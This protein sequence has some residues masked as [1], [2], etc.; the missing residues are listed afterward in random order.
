[1]LTDDR[2]TKEGMSSVASDW[3]R[4]GDA[5]GGESGAAGRTMITGEPSCPSA[6]AVS[7]LDVRAPIL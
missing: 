2:D 5:G 6:S 1:M 4:C 3:R 7:G